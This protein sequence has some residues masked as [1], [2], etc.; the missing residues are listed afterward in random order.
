[1]E[2]NTSGDYIVSTQEEYNNAVKNRKKP[3]VIEN[4]AD[5]IS[6]HTDVTVGKNGRCKTEGKTPVVITAKENAIVTAE[7][8]AHVAGFN[9]ANIIAK[10]N[11]KVEL[12]DEAF[13]NCF[14]HCNI[15]LKG[16]SKIAADGN[17][18]VHAYDEALVSASG[19]SKVYSYQK[20]TAK[21]SDITTI[22]AKDN[23]IVY[24]T[25]NC[26]VQASDNCLVFA[27]KNAK[28]VSQ[29]NCLVMTNGNPDITI[30][31]KCE[32]LNLDKVDEKNVMGALK[33][34]AQSKAVVERPLVAIQILKDN[35]PPTRKE[36]VNRRLNTMGLKDQTA[37]KNHLFSLIEAEP[38]IKNQTP[39]QN[40][41]KQLETARK[42]GYVQGVCEC[43]AAVGNEQNLGKKLLT[44][45]NVNRD[46][47]KKFAKP[48]TFKALE[49]GIFAQQKQEQN[50]SIKR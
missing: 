38:A 16:N 6:V 13:G 42:T 2:R 20:A 40:F 43:V 18:T 30:H 36:A 8:K 35:I 24:A 19:S 48:E 46:M 4:T 22:T 49:N 31:D 1:M 32:H 11:C 9:N 29:D 10:G 33:Q 12:H 28:I 37:I 44:E 3:I 7:G 26:K 41:E 27:E 25:D 15:T 17:C 34:M 23:C 50:Q 47:A 14:E 21:G 39:A 45:M 5:F